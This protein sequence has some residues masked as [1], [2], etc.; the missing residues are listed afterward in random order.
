M[1]DKVDHMTEYIFIGYIYIYIEYIY[2]EYIYIEDDDRYNQ[3]ERGVADKVDH[4]TF[5]F[6]EYIYIYIL[7]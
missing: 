4:N 6:T 1:A 3:G 5:T 2:N 7:H